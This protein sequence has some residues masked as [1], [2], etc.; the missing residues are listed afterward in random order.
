MN[1]KLQ[2]I[3]SPAPKDWSGPIATLSISFLDLKKELESFRNQLQGILNG[4][5]HKLDEL[6]KRTAPPIETPQPEKASAA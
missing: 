4:F 3:P 6:D 1:Q 2:S 5:A